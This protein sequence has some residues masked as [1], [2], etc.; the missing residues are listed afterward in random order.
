MIK[1]KDLL[2]EAKVFLDDVEW[3]GN[4]SSATAW[5]R[6]YKIKLDGFNYAGG[7]NSLE[8]R[9]EKKNLL[10]ALTGEEFGMDKKQVLK[11]YPALK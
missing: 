7:Y 2:D 5:A 6:K 4:R 10:K 1:L 3:E 9:G 11:W 8:V